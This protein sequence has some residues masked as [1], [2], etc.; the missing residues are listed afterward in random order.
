MTR[1]W[2]RRSV[3]WIRTWAAFRSASTPS[4]PRWQ[5][6]TST[7]SRRRRPRSNAFSAVI[8]A[9]D[10]FAQAIASAIAHESAHMLGL[11]AP[12]PAPAGLW[13]GRRAAAS[14]HNVTVDGGTPAPNYLMNRADP[15]RSA[16]SP[17]AGDI[18]A[19]SSAPL[20]WAYLR[21]RIALNAQVQAL[22]PPPT[23][24]SVEPAVVSF[25]SGNPGRD[26]HVPRGRIR[27]TAHD[28]A[29]SPR[30]TPPPTTFST[31]SWSTSGRSP[32]SSTSS[33]CRPRCTTCASSTAT[34]RRSRSSPDWWCNEPGTPTQPMAHRRAHG[35]AL[36]I[37]G[38]LLRGHHRPA[39]RFGPAGHAAGGRGPVTSS[40]T[41]TA[42]SPS[43]TS[44]SPRT[45]L[46]R[47]GT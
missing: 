13:G 36:G 44:S 25:P 7:S 41:S 12:G 22:Y 15:S 34:A 45:S 1:I 47:R 29:P 33:S 18:P 8:N 6:P 9:A 2:K 31:R 11:T 24:D 39:G 17:G 30:A 20:N 42:S 16:R 37:A 26:G 32:A 38:P 5:H 23:L 21:D 40:R 43:S 35:A 28:R 10:A 27:R 3:P 19:P 4:T 14:D 46:S